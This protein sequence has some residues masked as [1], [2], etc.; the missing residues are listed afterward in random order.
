MTDAV[1]A[2]GMDDRVGAAIAR[3]VQ[4]GAGRAASQSGGALPVPI[5]SN[6]RIHP[7]PVSPCTNKPLSTRGERSSGRNP[8]QRLEFRSRV[9]GMIDPDTAHLAP[10]VM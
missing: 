2:R 8:F 6:C 9:A 10:A 5:E 7:E 1:R 4:P 3:H